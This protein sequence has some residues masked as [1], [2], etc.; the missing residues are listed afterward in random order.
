MSAEIIKYQVFDFA[1]GQVIEREREIDS[2]K[3]LAG[4]AFFQMISKRAP[5]QPLKI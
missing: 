4:N 1:K 2:S 5:V 3:V